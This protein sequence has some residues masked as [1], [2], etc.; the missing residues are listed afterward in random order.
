MSNSWRLH[1]LQPTRLLC[2]WDS[3][4]ENTGVGCHA[5]SLFPCLICIWGAGV[6]LR[7]HTLSPF[8]YIS[9]NVGDDSH[10]CGFYGILPTPLGIQWRKNGTHLW[11]QLMPLKTFLR[12]LPG[13]PAP[14]QGTT[15]PYWVAGAGSGL[16]PSS[17]L[18]GS[19]ASCLTNAE[20]CSSFLRWDTPSIC[21]T[22]WV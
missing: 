21:S 10:H 11:P 8:T 6:V 19:G 16:F 12:L 14:S 2:P 22:P 5:L 3:P 4:G 18:A 9:Y 20:G 17:L 13:A 7:M 1:G 15:A